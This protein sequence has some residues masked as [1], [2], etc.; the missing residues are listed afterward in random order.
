MKLVYYNDC[1]IP[2]EEINE[3]EF[4]CKDVAL[5][6]MNTH[7]CLGK[8]FIDAATVHVHECRCLCE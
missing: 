1:I 5:Q 2:K 8:L 4:L 3:Q 6:L 7:A